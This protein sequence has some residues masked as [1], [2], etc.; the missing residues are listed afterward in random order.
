MGRLFAYMHFPILSCMGFCFAVWFSHDRV[1]GQESWPN[2]RGP[3]GNGSSL[4]AKPPTK[5]DESSGV[6]WKSSIDGEGSSTPI[7]WDQ[8][9]IVLSALKT[10]RTDPDDPAV[11]AFASERDVRAPG[12][13]TRRVPGAARSLDVADMMG[14]SRDSR[15]DDRSGGQ[16]SPPPPINL[17]QFL[18]S[19][20]DLKTGAKNWQVSVVE[21]VPHEAGHVTNNFASCSPS[22]DGESIFIFWGSRG[23]FCL[24]MQGKRLWS[25]DLGRKYTRTPFGQ[26]GE[27]AS[28]AI[29]KGLLVVPWDHESESYVAALDTQNGD[30]KWKSGRK[31]KSTWATPTIVEFAG[32]TQVIM[33][34]KSVRSYD[35]LD[36]SLLWECDD[37]TDNAIPTPVVYGQNVIV[38]SGFG[39]AACYSISLLSRGNVSRNPEFVNWS[40]NFSTPYVPSPTIYQDKLYFLDQYQP[41]LACLNAETGQPIYARKELKGLNEVYASPGAADGKIFVVDRSGTTAVIDAND[42]FEILATNRIGDEETFDA[43][44]VFIGNK[45]L[46]R[47][48]KHLFCIGPAE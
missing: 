28:A 46:L 47:S 13:V 43:S 4:T 11:I 44:P 42:K 1:F 20:F 18:V 2:W 38:M 27:G 23:I 8:Q 26:F 39:R 37:Q 21:E 24:D 7:V 5:W 34:G 29:H 9:V 19:S 14:G 17:Y 31:E 48:N 16:K 15:R 22:T 25:A 36:G 12:P 33:N 41:I 30:L 32:Q 6:L 3:H 35:L 10:D 40:Y 45:L